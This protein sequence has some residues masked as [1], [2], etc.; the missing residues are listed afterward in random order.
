MAVAVGLVNAPTPADAGTSAQSALAPLPVPKTG[1]YLGGFI[2]PSGKGT[3]GGTA[4]TAAAGTEINNE[5]SRELAEIGS[6]D[7]AIGRPL[8]IVHVYEN[9]GP[10]SSLVPNAVLNDLAG[11]AAV[12][13]IN[14]SCE[15][16][17][18]DYITDA[19]ITNGTWDSYITSYA[20]QLK[21]Y[22]HPVFMRWYREPNLSDGPDWQ[23]CSGGTPAGYPSCTASSTVATTSAYVAAW[24]HVYTL[25]QQAGATN[26]SF[27]WNPGLS[28]DFPSCMASLLWP[29]SQY[30]NWIGFDG[31]SRPAPTNP[32]NPSFTQQFGAGYG[33]VTGASY[34]GLP[35]LVGETGAV[36]S[37]QVP[38][39][40][41]V[42]AALD[43][44]N[45]NDIHA[46]MYFDSDRSTESGCSGTCDW[47][48]TTSGALKAMQNLVQD[49]YFTPSFAQTD[50]AA[51]HRH[52]H[53]HKPNRERPRR[54]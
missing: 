30:V 35:V 28:Y 24:R 39:L 2:D 16:S 51:L 1:A 19:S 47:A 7:A 38:Y 22:G 45:F 13:M 42:K 44:G 37:N 21:A 33:I 20:D 26:V 48:L 50:S 18:T 32:P 4:N 10:A 43:S 41:S 9:W 36:G 46:F 5:D 23:K 27:V 6:F 17:P 40:Q 34:G 29:G 31:Y 14:W 52:S 53:V 54:R 15:V 11:Q 3:S 12:P 25:F 8:D 49:P